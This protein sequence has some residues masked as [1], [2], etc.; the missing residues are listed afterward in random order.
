[1][2]SNILKASALFVALL[3]P[4]GAHAQGVVG[5][6]ANG[7]DQGEAKVG[8]VGAVVGGAVGA[9]TGGAGAILGVDQR[10]RFHEYVL[11]EHIPSYRYD[12]DVR[13]GL[14]LPP[15]GVQ[16]YEIPP[17]YG[18]V[19]DRYTVVNDRTVLVDPQTHRIIQVIE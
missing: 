6:V 14:V 3:A 10:P 15:D 8:P 12:E 9:V 11:R 2:I 4:L 7:A 17:E 18:V 13:V 19:G 5:G 1:M 16:Y